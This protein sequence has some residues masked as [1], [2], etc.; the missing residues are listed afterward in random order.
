MVEKQ[1]HGFRA[2]LDY[3]LKHNEFIN[4]CFRKFVSGIMRVWGVFVPMDEK[5]I[6]ISGH[7]RKYNDS[8]RTMLATSTYGPWKT[9]RT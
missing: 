9:Q 7:T 1:M 4:K 2:R 6:I 5:M 8:P 3:L